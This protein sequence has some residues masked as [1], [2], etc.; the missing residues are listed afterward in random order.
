MGSVP[1]F[2][3]Q[4]EGVLAAQAALSGESIDDYVTRA[5]AARLVADLTERNGLELAPLLERLASLG[6]TPPVPADPAA[7]AVMAILRDPDRLGALRRTGLLDSP[8]EAA[9]D[10]IVQMASDALAVPAAA[11]TLLDDHRQFFKSA[12]GE[13]MDDVTET[14]IERSICQHTI[15]TGESLIVEDAR[16]HPLLSTHPAV[17]EDSLVAYAGVPVADLDGHFIATLCVWDGQPRQWTSGHVQT[18]V[19]LAGL[20]QERIVALGG[21]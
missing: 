14:S 3:D 10:R 7:A 11:I 19:D 6:L 18:L 8:R 12:V 21:K 15:A 4:L 9:Y 1:R 13:G 16:Q 5:V 20:L 17:L 2:D